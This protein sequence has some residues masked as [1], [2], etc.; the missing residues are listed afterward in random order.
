MAARSCNDESPLRAFLPFDV[1]EGHRTLVP[2]ITELC[3]WLGCEHEFFFRRFYMIKHRAEITG[4][5]NSDPF[6]ERRFDRIVSGHNHFTDTGV[7]RGQD[8]VQYPFHFSDTTI[9]T[10]L[11]DVDSGSVIDG[12]LFGCF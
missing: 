5:N 2:I 7:S 12:D 1:F 6:Y 11:T 10:E 8:T 4:W 3:R 9:E